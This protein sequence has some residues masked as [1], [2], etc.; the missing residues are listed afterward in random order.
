MIDL[1][2]VFFYVGGFDLCFRQVMKPTTAFI[3]A[4]LTI[5]SFCQLRTRRQM[6]HLWQHWLCFAIQCNFHQTERVHDTCIFAFI[7]GRIITASIII[8][9]DNET[10]IVWTTLSQLTIRT[11]IDQTRKDMQLVSRM[12][13]LFL[14]PNQMQVWFVLTIPMHPQLSGANREEMR[15]QCNE[16]IMSTTFM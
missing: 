12:S 13:N 14:L 6:L 11:C 1:S 15:W 8:T 10:N 7:P 4:L 9:M 2:T 16:Y 5:N 3:S